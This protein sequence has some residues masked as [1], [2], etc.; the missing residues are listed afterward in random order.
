VVVAAALGAISCSLLTSLDG[1][2]SGASAADASGP[3]GAT[4]PDSGT[5]DAPGDAAPDVLK[6]YAEEVADDAPLSYWRFG[7]A[8]GANAADER[9]AHAGLYA[10][11]YRVGVPG[12]LRNDDDTAV[13]LDGG[14]VTFGDVYGFAGTVPY[15]IELWAKPAVL[16]ATYRNLYTKLESAPPR[17]GHFLWVHATEGIVTERDEGYAWD[18]PDGSQIGAGGAPPQLGVWIHVVGTYD[19]SRLRF[20]LNGSLVDTS[21]AS[22]AISDV[23]TPFVVGANKEG[24]EQFVGT[25][26]E[27]AVYGKV[28]SADRVLAHYHAAGY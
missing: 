7:E 27:V 20:Y 9:G 8:S 14:Y 28:L 5:T 17:S 15:S 25:V 26:D 16:D 11:S 10:G 13:D 22:F 23:T 24:A 12:A 6:S 1:Y 2:T 21:S 4:T 18:P 19:G 3:D